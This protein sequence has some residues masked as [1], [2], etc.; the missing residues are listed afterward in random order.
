M[1]GCLG[2]E[3]V[4]TFNFNFSYNSICEYGFLKLYLIISLST[5]YSF[6][7]GVLRNKRLVLSNTNATSVLLQ[8][9]FYLKRHNENKHVGQCRQNPKH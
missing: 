4:F 5:V 6:F 2:D 9:I 3:D 7:L 1:S 8:Y